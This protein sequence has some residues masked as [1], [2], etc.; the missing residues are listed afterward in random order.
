MKLSSAVKKLSSAVKTVLHNKEIEL[1]CIDC[2]HIY[3]AGL[4]RNGKSPRDLRWSIAKVLDCP[5]FHKADDVRNPKSQ[6]DLRW[7]IAK[8]LDCL[9]IHK[10]C[11]LTTTHSTTLS[12]RLRSGF[13]KSTLLLRYHAKSDECTMRRHAVFFWPCGMR[14]VVAVVISAPLIGAHDNTV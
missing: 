3:K 4:V 5:H 8:V 2:L 11:L 7:C 14:G 6:R 10:F 12:A 1:V 13:A 9:H